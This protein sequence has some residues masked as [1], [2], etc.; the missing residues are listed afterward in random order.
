MIFSIRIVK[1]PDAIPVKD[2]CIKDEKERDSSAGQKQ[3]DN[4]SLQ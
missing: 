2:S 1:P 4:G 3:I